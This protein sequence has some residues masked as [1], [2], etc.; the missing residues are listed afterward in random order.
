MRHSVTL[1]KKSAVQKYLQ[2][3]DW[4]TDYVYSFQNL[5]FYRNWKWKPFRFGKGFGIFG[6]I[7][8]DDSKW[9]PPNGILGII[10]YNL[11]FF[12]SKIGAK[13]FFILIKWLVISFY[14]HPKIIVTTILW[15]SYSWC[16][17]SFPICCPST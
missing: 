3:G 13:L 11:I 7:F 10:F 17:A 8:S 14:S 5:G 2:P 12:M 4:L 9:N 1:V 6:L 15:A 16:C